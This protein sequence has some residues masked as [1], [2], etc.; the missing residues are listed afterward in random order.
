M[1]VDEAALREKANVIAT[2]IRK[3]NLR[4]GMT[5]QDERLPKALHQALEDSGKVITEDEMETMLKEYYQLHGWGEDMMPPG[6]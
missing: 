5:I 3:F 4:E 2:Q 1:E 6:N